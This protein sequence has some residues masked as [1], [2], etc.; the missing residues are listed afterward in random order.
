MLRGRDHGPRETCAA[1]PNTA[2][3][4]DVPQPELKRALETA[5][6]DID[7]LNDAQHRTVAAL[8]ENPADGAR[9]RAADDA[10]RAINERVKATVQTHARLQKASL[11]PCDG[12]DTLTLQVTQQPNPKPNRAAPNPNPDAPGDAAA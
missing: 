8:L 12:G 2:R 1:A 9:Q 4:R 10:T 3:Q 5:A 11:T 6:R 7:Q